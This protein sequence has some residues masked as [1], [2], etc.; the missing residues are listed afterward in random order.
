MR[1]WRMFLIAGLALAVASPGFAQSPILVGPGDPVIGV[2]DG[3]LQTYLCPT[4]SAGDLDTLTLPPGFFA[5]PDRVVTVDFGEV[6]PVPSDFGFVTVDIDGTTF[7]KVVKTVALEGVSPG[8]RV[9]IESDRTL[10]WNAGREVHEIFDGQHRFVLLSVSDEA[11]L[12][13]MDLPAGWS[14]RSRVLP[15]DLTIFEPTG[16]PTVYQDERGNNWEQIPTTDRPLAARSITLRRTKTGK[17]KLV[18]RASDDGVLAPVAGGVDDPAQVPARIDFC[19]AAGRSTIT[20][21]GAGWTATANGVSFSNPD[22]PASPSPVKRLKLSAGRSLKVL[23]RE[24]GLPLDGS[25][26]QLGVRLTTG[27]VRNCALFGPSTVRRDEVD[28]FKASKADPGALADCSDEALG[29]MGTCVPDDNDVPVLETADGVEFVRTPDSRFDGLDG[30]PF[31]P[32]YVT[33]DGLRM[34]YVDEGP[35]DGEVMLLLHGEPTWSYLYRD[36]IVPMAASGFRVIAPDLIG[37]GRSDKPVGIGVHTYAQHIDWVS[38]FIEALDLHD[39]TLFS[40]DWGG[41]IGLRIVGEQPERFARVVAANTTLPVI[42]PGANPYTVP[43][44]VEIDCG[45]GDFEFTT[46][47]SWIDYALQAPALRPSEVVQGGTVSDL[48]PEQAKAY[49][50]PYPSFIY[51]AAIRALPSMIAAVEDENAAAWAELQQFEK[52]FLTLW[53]ELDPNLGSQAFQDYLINN[54]PGAQGQFHERFPASHFVQEEIGAELAGNVILF[55]LM[56]PLDGP[57]MCWMPAVPESVMDCQLICERINEC[58]PTQA[59]SW[60]A[61]GC[62]F[63]VEPYL[64]ALASAEMQTC[65]LA[66]ACGTYDGFQDLID[67][68][69]LQLIVGGILTPDPVKLAQC[70][71]VSPVVT[72]CDPDATFFATACQGLAFVYTLESMQQIGACA[73]ATCPDLR[74]CLLAASCTFFFDNAGALPD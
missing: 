66:Q 60:C 3:L 52:P 38:R 62:E 50:A 27:S 13:A 35:V 61:N 68:C 37:M 14:L 64:T 40:H 65:M 56:N 15:A 44:P 70:A 58:L 51:K 55:T 67:D 48:A 8:I 11:V 6:R 33:I 49:D 46:F 57:G 20:F 71:F 16:F 24:V 43:D 39:V 28:A 22:A 54:I 26:G 10:V 45:L 2:Q 41:L 42:P 73:T 69:V 21:P 19:S 30:Y 34:H 12:E 1:T 74:D 47:Q 23:A 36:L 59:A 32:H 17:Q 31:A 25:E 4:C 5:M 53:G 9:D 18:F 72:A 7:Q 29:C 63:S